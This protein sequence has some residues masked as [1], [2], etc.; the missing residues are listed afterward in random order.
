[1]Y[2]HPLKRMSFLA[3]QD[4]SYGT[5]DR[6][7]RAELSKEQ[8]AASSQGRQVIGNFALLPVYSHV[9]F[10]PLQIPKYISR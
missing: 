9:G 10:I 8:P 6:R 4:P 7:K 5:A 3:D 2:A 1:M